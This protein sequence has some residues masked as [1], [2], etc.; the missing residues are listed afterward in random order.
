MQNIPLTFYK[1]LCCVVLLPHQKK[2]ERG[3]T[4][5][6]WKWNIFCLIIQNKKKNHIIIQNKCHTFHFQILFD[7]NEKSIESYKKKWKN[8]KCILLSKRDLKGYL[9]YGSNY[10]TFWERENYR[11]SKKI[12]GWGRWWIA[13]AQGIFR[14]MKTFCMIP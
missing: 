1:S 7:G 9:L 5:Y 2:T 12:S 6:Q 3:S 10:M 13:G 11:E 14:P 4:Y 8:L